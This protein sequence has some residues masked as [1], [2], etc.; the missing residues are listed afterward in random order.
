M[1]SEEIAK[2][3]RMEME[4]WGKCET[5]EELH[6]RYNN[7]LDLRELGV[8]DKAVAGLEYA[9]CAA[10]LLAQQVVIFRIPPELSLP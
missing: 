5:I 3:L 10:F 7:R 9:R 8:P 6:D 4:L 1:N 2:T